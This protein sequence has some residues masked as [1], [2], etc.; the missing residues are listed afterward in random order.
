[1]SISER[2]RLKQYLNALPV[3]IDLLLVPFDWWDFIR[4]VKTF[5][6]RNFLQFILLLARGMSAFHYQ[7]VLS[8]V[9]EYNSSTLKS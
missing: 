5:M 6:G 7:T 2:S 8:V 9:G 1:M 3:T 4:E